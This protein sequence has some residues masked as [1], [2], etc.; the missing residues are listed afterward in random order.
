MVIFNYGRDCYAHEILFRMQFNCT[1]NTILPFN[2]FKFKM[3][4]NA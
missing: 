3:I 4:F 1:A 2:M